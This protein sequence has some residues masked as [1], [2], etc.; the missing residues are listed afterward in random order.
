MI[1]KISLEL[2][3]SAR[4]LRPYFQSHQIKVKTYH[5]LKQVIRKPEIASI[6]VAWSVELFKFNLKFE[7][8]GPIKR[9]CLVDFMVELP[10][11]ESDNEGW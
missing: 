9:E 4:R 11:S 7:L 5:P 3:T 8:R 1:K 10:S 6:M 2:I